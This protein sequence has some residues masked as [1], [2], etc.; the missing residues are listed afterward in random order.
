ML[1]DQQA[2]FLEKNVCAPWPL[3]FLRLVSSMTVLPALVYLL[4][5]GKRLIFFF[6]S[7]VY[8]EVGLG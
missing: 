8:V 4:R 6:A 2:Y 3:C 5:C 1:V 7:N